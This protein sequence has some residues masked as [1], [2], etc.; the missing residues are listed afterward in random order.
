[1]G[2]DNHA[3]LYIDGEITYVSAFYDFRFRYDEN[4]D[5]VIA[6]NYHSAVELSEVRYFTDRLTQPEIKAM[7]EEWLDAR[8]GELASRRLPRQE[9]V[10]DAPTKIHRSD[11]KCAE[12]AVVLARRTATTATWT[13]ATVAAPNAKCK[14]L[15]ER[16]KRRC[17]IVSLQL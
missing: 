17:H 9:L 2:D 10:T 13:T 11:S 15:I 7:Y 3:A 4:Q 6:D 5:A 14:K 8:E 16:G 12:T 1:M